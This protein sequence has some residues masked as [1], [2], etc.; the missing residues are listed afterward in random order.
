MKS[1]NLNNFSY[2]YNK[3]FSGSEISIFVKVPQK[4]FLGYLSQSF[5]EKMLKFKKGG[6]L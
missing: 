6:I 2:G 1:L 5:K 4:S 3:Q